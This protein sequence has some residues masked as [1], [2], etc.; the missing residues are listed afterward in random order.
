[1][2]YF[3]LLLFILYLHT[4]YKRIKTYTRRRKHKKFIF[5]YYVKKYNKTTLFLFCNINLYHYY[6]NDRED[7]LDLIFIGFLIVLDTFNEM[8]TNINC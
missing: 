3:I 6:I 4:F 1:M 5:K 2:L 7:F 8:L